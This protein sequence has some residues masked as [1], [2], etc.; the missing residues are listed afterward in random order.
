M[1]NSSGRDDQT[2]QIEADTKKK[3][4]TMQTNVNKHRDEV[5]VGGGRGL[6]N[7][8]NLTSPAQHPQVIKTLLDIVVKVEPKLHPNFKV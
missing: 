5:C 1:Q 2:M 6:R 3:L 8:V 7:T 4:E